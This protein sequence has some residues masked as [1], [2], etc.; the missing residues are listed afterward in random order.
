[1]YNYHIKRIF[2]YFIILMLKKQN[3]FTIEKG[4]YFIYI[5]L[6]PMICP[7]NSCSLVFNRIDM[8]LKHISLHVSYFI[9]ID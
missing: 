2:L 3:I 8:Y 9:I 1:M 5:L 6:V 4:R 7:I